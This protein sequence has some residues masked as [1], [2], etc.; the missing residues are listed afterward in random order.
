MRVLYI[1]KASGQSLLMRKAMERRGHDVFHVDPYVVLMDQHLLRFWTWHTGAFLTADMASRYVKK[2][3][4][5]RQFDVAFVDNGEMVSPSLVQYAK[6]RSKAVALFNRDNPFVPRDGLR[7]RTFLAALPHYDLYVT[8]RVSTAEVAP[9]FGAKAV[10]RTNLFADETLHKPVPPTAEEMQRFGSQVSFVGTWFPERGAFMETL[11]NRGVPLRIIGARWSRAE[12]FGKIKHVVTEGYLN[13]SEYSAA[14]RSSRIAIGML[15]KG[16]EDLHTARSIEIPAMGILFCGE[17]T[18][19]HL[20]MYEDGKE[21]V[22]WSSAEEC[23]DVCLN[24]LSTPTRIDEIA[25]AGRARALSNDNWT[26]NTM[27]R[28][29]VE[30]IERSEAKK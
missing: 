9:S 28:I 29:L 15:S 24:L 21:A 20:E 22:F 2:Q 11:L 16:N 7:W 26:E 17:R 8:R 4:G 13:S 18:T 10:I 1:G 3:I 19:E 30:A 25:A 6:A 27:E 5:D 14:V 23:A 12:N